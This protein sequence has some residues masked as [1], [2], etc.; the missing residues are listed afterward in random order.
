MRSVIVL[1]CLGLATP[2]MAQPKKPTRAQKAKARDLYEEGQ[3]FYNIGEYDQAIEKFKASYVQ[4]PAPLLLFNIAQAYRL[5]GDCEQALRSYETYLREVPKPAN[6]RQVDQAVQICEQKIAAETPAEPPPVAKDPAQPEP[7]RV[8][9]A[10]AE[11]ESEP[12][13]EVDDEPEAGARPGR[14]KKI[15]GI[16]VGATGLALTATGA[17]FGLQASSQASDIEEFDGTWDQSWED[18]E[19]AQRRNRVLAPVLIGTGVAAIAGGVFMYL[20]GDREA[21]DAAELAVAPT[22]DG[23]ALYVSGRF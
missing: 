3:R 10:P 19:S 15:I 11:P 2:A 18:K 6:K 8:A 9:E 21:T 23:G 13:A 14:T 16:A 20:W 7:T 1:V 22:A 4:V 17:Y 12:E 5:S